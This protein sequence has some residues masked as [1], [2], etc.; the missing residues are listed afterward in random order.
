[1]NYKGKIVESFRTCTIVV[2]SFVDIPF[3]C[4]LNDKLNHS[5]AILVHNSITCTNLVQHYCCLIPSIEWN[6]FL[7]KH[8]YCNTLFM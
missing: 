6:Y 1:M 4:D 3:Q 2:S 8:N 7:G 5:Q